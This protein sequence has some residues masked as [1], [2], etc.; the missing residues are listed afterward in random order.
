MAEIEKEKWFRRRDNTGWDRYIIA[1][2]P[3]DFREHALACARG[4]RE[5]GGK[6]KVIQDEKTKKW[7]CYAKMI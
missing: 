3:F 4:M 7:L 6:A 2:T 5:L 1:D